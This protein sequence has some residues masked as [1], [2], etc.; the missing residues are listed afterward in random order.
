MDEKI[1]NGLIPIDP[2]GSARLAVSRNMIA[3]MDTR[4]RAI[5]FAT[6]ARAGQV[7]KPGE[8]YILH[9]LRA[10][11]AMVKPD[12]R[13]AVV[14]HDVVEGTAIAL[15]NLRAAGFNEAILAAVDALTKRLG[16]SRMDAAV[17]AKTNPIVVAVKLADN[18]D[19]QDMSRIENPSDR[20]HARLEEYKAVRAFLL[21]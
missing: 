19:K 10:M 11:H 13:I 7:E 3:T 2:V 15:D 14:L 9:P 16:V 4:E 20:D 12:E 17:R 6:E 8:P 1:C 18:C 21:S 5:S